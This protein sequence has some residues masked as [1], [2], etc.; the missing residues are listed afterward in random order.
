MGS[1]VAVQTETL[2]SLVRA[3]SMRREVANGVPLTGT[4]SANRAVPL[5]ET[6]WN[7]ETAM[8]GIEKNTEVDVPVRTAYN[9]WT[10][11]EEFPRF[12]EGV[13]EVRQL[14]PKRLHW[15]A[16]IGGKEVEWTSE[17]TQQLPDERITWRSTSGAYNAG[18]V[19]FEPLGPSRTRITLRIEYEPE[20]AVE[21]TGSVLGIV[22]ARVSGDLERFKEFIE[23]RGV[24]TGQW[25]GEIH[26]QS[27]MPNPEGIMPS[28]PEGTRQTGAPLRT[29]RSQEP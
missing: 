23:N 8:P 26:G 3:G 18:A 6:T 14:D 16:E 4:E 25:R 22:S 5:F 19:S 17:I 13:K 24:E 12:M 2:A 21:T 20:G 15:R 7:Q 1:V 9:Q 27:V 29:P 10:Q 11:F 28:S